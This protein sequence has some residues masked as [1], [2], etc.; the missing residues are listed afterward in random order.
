MTKSIG[1]VHGKNYRSGEGAE[2][3]GVAAGGS[4]D[5]AHLG[6]WFETFTCVRFTCG[7]FARPLHARVSDH[8]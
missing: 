7:L 2:A 8:G 4:D 1:K 5:W 6:T 3:F